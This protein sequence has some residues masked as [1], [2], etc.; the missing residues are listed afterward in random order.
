MAEEKVSTLTELYDRTRKCT[1]IKIPNNALI[2]IG[3]QEDDIRGLLKDQGITDALSELVKSIRGV[4]D[5]L[6]VAGVGEISVVVKGTKYLPTETHSMRNMLD[7]LEFHMESFRN[8]RRPMCKLKFK[9]L[10]GQDDFSGKYEAAVAIVGTKVPSF[11]GKSFAATFTA[12]KVVMLMLGENLR[13][14]EVNFTRNIYTFRNVG[15]PNNYTKGIALANSVINNYQFDMNYRIVMQAMYFLC[16][17]EL[18]KLYSEKV[19]RFDS[20]TSDGVLLKDI[21]EKFQAQ[22]LISECTREGL[23]GIDYAKAVVSMCNFPFNSFYVSDKEGYR[24]TAGSHLVIDRVYNVGEEEV[25]LDVFNDWSE[26]VPSWT[27]QEWDQ[28]LKREQHLAGMDQA[29]DT[30]D[31]VTAVADAVPENAEAIG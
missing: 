21:L 9:Y 31:N 24:G 14:R 27:P 1:G 18:E 12:E 16:S 19:L 10:N 28:L 2:Y 5:A 22:G 17:E 30:A 6:M 15:S 26:R 3:V 8:S 11:R 13:Q 23:D 25:P 4:S 7:M 29:S 20:L